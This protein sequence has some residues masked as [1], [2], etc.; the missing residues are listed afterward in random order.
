MADTRAPGSS[1]SH[2]SRASHGSNHGRGGQYDKALSKSTERIYSATQLIAAL[3]SGLAAVRDQLQVLSILDGTALSWPGVSQAA[4]DLEFLIDISAQQITRMETTKNSYGADLARA[5]EEN[6]T[7]RETLSESNHARDGLQ[8]EIFSLGKELKLLQAKLSSQDKEVQQQK[9]ELWTLEKQRADL[10]SECEKYK[11]DNDFM[12]GEMS[13]LRSQVAEQSQQ[14][15]GLKEELAGRRS[16]VKHLMGLTV[17]HKDQIELLKQQLATTSAQLQE[18]QTILSQVRQ[19][20]AHFEAEAGR[21]GEECARLGA[22]LAKSVKEV[23]K[24]RDWQ[25]VIKKVRGG[26]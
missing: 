14:I 6:I 17:D 22:E 24:M 3:K 25:D 5:Q 1:G 13:T 16:D 20:K 18:S 10:A 7:L 26:V 8:Q 11:Q 15:T 21:L 23:E 4:D 19:D 2:A 12:E 9:Q